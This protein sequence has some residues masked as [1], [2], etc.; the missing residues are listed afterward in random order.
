M[1]SIVNSAS[2]WSEFWT[3]S[4]GIELTEESFDDAATV[5]ALTRLASRDFASATT[6]DQVNDTLSGL[7][8]SV[9]GSPIALAFNPIFRSAAGARRGELVREGLATPK[10]RDDL[11]YASLEDVDLAALPGISLRDVDLS[12]ASLQGA[13]LSDLSLRNSTHSRTNLRGATVSG[14]DFTGADL[15]GADLREVD[16]QRATL[17]RIKHNEWNQWDGARLTDR[18]LLELSQDF[19]HPNLRSATL[20]ALARRHMGPLIPGGWSTVKQF[21]IDRFHARPGEA[22]QA[23]AAARRASQADL[24]VVKSWSN[25]VLQQSQAAAD[26]KQEYVVDAQA[27]QRIFPILDN[28]PPQAHP[29]A[30]LLIRLLSNPSV[31][32][33]SGV[34]AAMRSYLVAAGYDVGED[35]RPDFDAALGTNLTAAHPLAVKIGAKTGRN[36][37]PVVGFSDSGMP[38]KISHP[39]LAP[40]HHTQ[41]EGVDRGKAR[42]ARIVMT[43]AGSRQPTRLMGFATDEYFLNNESSKV[44]QK[45]I[46][47][48]RAAGGRVF[49]SSHVLFEGDMRTAFD[50]VIR[51]NPDMLFVMSAGNAGVNLDAPP[52]WHYLQQEDAQIKRSLAEYENVVLVG[53]LMPNGFLHNDSN[54]GKNSVQLAAPGTR[55]LGVQDASTY[56]YDSGTSFSA[57]LVANIAA[58]MWVQYRDFTPRQVAHILHTTSHREETLTNSIGSGGKLMPDAALTVAGLMGLMTYG[59]T[60]AWGATSLYSRTTPDGEPSSRPTVK[61]ETLLTELN[62]LSAQDGATNGAPDR[63]DPEVVEAAVYRLPLEDQYQKQLLN[64]LT[65]FSPGQAAAHLGLEAADPLV[66]LARQ[67]QDRQLQR[68]AEVAINSNV[69]ENGDPRRDGGFAKRVGSLN[70]GTATGSSGSEKSFLEGGDMPDF[71]NSL[72]R[73]SAGREELSEFMVIYRY[74][75][76]LG[77][78]DDYRQLKAQAPLIAKQL[79]GSAAKGMLAAAQRDLADTQAQSRTVAGEI[80]AIKTTLGS[81]DATLGDVEARLHELPAGR[82][83]TNARLS[84]GGLKG[85][86]TNGEGIRLVKGPGNT[87]YFGDDSPFQPQR[88]KIKGEGFLM[89]PEDASDPGVSSRDPKKAGLFPRPEVPPVSV[90]EQVSTEPGGQSDPGNAS[91]DPK[92]IGVLLNP[93]PKVKREAPQILFQKDK[94][95]RFIFTTPLDGLPANPRKKDEGGVANCVDAVAAF[96]RAWSALSHHDGGDGLTAKVTAAQQSAQTLMASL[97][98]QVDDLS[99]AVKATALDLVRGLENRLAA[100]SEEYS[101]E[102][103]QFVQKLTSSER[104]QIPS[105]LVNFGADTFAA[106]VGFLG[107][108]MTP[109]TL[110]LN[111]LGWRGAGAQS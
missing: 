26:N 94:T 45:D 79:L 76:F 60:P 78:L 97:R 87:I 27:W 62:T 106:V 88:A 43:V 46:D 49:L 2:S 8:E 92:L 36:T 93:V 69:L 47:A 111:L 21:L 20:A 80:A 109:L 82:V 39:A 56:D 59:V 11:S 61:L 73:S 85:T 19:I 99:G 51:N 96:Q 14:A 5:D 84:E 37:L 38:A 9:R 53:N 35:G 64:L 71:S 66:T 104:Q 101:Q 31:Q 25:Q 95:G 7:T 16:F 55:I 108:V 23:V 17:K 77:T 22:Q 50:D 75:S 67:M 15:R 12:R 91:D 63:V 44:L 30:N 34:V 4:G 81:L 29:A 102:N 40:R 107:W 86:L 74:T 105:D 83:A 1:I 10:P 3:G 13:N 72:L 65:P 32:F 52:K 98:V 41:R 33:E 54:Y 24:A 103:A 6:L 110:L 48:V 70:L 58:A 18:Q 90:K 42:H 68:E 57:P 100:I 28:F 89:T